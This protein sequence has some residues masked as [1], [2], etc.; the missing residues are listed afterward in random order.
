[1]RAIVVN[2][3]TLAAKLTNNKYQILS[4]SILRGATQKDGWNYL[5][6]KN[7]RLATRE[8]FETFGVEFHAEY[9]LD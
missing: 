3:H 4:A 5:D 2:N 6:G 1:M 7:Y 9:L 8:D